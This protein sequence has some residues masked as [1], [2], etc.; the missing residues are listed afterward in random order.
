MCYRCKRHLRRYCHSGCNYH[1]DN[2]HCYIYVHG[3]NCGWL[4]I[5]PENKILYKYIMVRDASS[6]V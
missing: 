3:K 1:N 6:T 2:G 4:Q 5:Q